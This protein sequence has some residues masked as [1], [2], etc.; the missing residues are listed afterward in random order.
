MA[1]KTLGTRQKLTF[2]IEPSTR[3]GTAHPRNFLV[4]LARGRKAGAH[5]EGGHAD[6]RRAL[7]TMGKD[8]KE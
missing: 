8:D 3:T 7:R 6:V 2:R 5:T 4:P 1:N